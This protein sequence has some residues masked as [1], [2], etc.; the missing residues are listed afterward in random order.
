MYKKAVKN[1]VDKRDLDD[2]RVYV[3]RQDRI[4]DDKVNRLEQH[5]R[6]DISEIKRGQETI[7]NHIMRLHK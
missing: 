2:L 7:L 4:T 6:E 5:M 3:D 1:Q